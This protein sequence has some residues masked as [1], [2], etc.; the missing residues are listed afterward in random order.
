MYFYLLPSFLP[1]SP[2]YFLSSLPL[3]PTD[4]ILPIPSSLFP[5]SFIVVSV[6]LS[7]TQTVSLVYKNHTNLSN[8]YALFS[9]TL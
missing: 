2:L 7:V 9:T 3:L 8:P 5:I 1:F 6:G 4:N